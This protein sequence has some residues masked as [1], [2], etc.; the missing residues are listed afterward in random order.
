MQDIEVAAGG[1]FR[2]IGMA[3]IAEDRPPALDTLKTYQL[4]G[5]SW[6]ATDSSD[7]PIAYIL[8][9]S[10]NRHAH[11]E[12][13]TVHPQHARHAVGRALIEEVARWALARQ[14]HGM[15]LTTFRDVQWNA[16][17]YSRLG[18]V[19]VPRHE[20]SDAMRRIVEAED[21]HGLARWARVVMKKLLTGQT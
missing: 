9:E 1:A 4:A 8:V 12:Q 3:A 14:F 13:V 20:W 7:E 19:E 10:V 11:I 2:E 17:Y 21:A 16:P 15:T 6:V 5:R 18:F